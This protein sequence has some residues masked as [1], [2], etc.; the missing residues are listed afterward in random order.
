MSVTAAADLQALQARLLVLDLREQ[1]LIQ[2]SM[3]SGA[4]SELRELLRVVHR[5]QPQRCNWNLRGVTPGTSELIQ[6]VSRAQ[7][8]VMEQQE[9]AHLFHGTTPFGGTTELAP[10]EAQVKK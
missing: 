4:T 2:G 8:A 6:L 1:M 10:V 7:V 9:V 3:T 5:D